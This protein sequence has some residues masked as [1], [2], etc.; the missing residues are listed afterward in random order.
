M[1]NLLSQIEWKMSLG[2]LITITVLVATVIAGWVRLEA[3]MSTHAANIT[4]LERDDA[5]IRREIREVKERADA[6][7][8]KVANDMTEMKMS[9]RTISTNL[10]WIVKQ[11]SKST[12]TP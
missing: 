4:R 7:L 9:L 6:K 11:A 12:T 1:S 8:D 5:E 10:D 2:N 3:S